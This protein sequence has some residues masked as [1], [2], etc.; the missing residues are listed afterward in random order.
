[1]K[2][3][4]VIE[5]LAETR[6]FFVES[7]KV[8]GFD[9]I[10][11]ENDRIAIERVQEELPDL[12]ISETITPKLDGYS[13]LST[14]RQNPITAIIPFIFVTARKTWTDIRFGMELGA[15]DYLTKPCTIEELLRAIATRI[16]KQ[17]TLKQWY[18]LE[19]QKTPEKS[20]HNTTA[21]AEVNQSIHPTGSPMREVFKFIEANYQQPITL[22]EVA[23]A[24]GY[25]P[26]YL[27]DLMRRQSGKTVHQWIVERRMTAAC[28]LLLETNRSV[29]EIAT[30][31][32]YSY[33]GCFFRQFRISFGMAPKAW[34]KTQVERQS[35]NS[36]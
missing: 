4:M 34:R 21:Q 19:H 30:A 15:D 16:E 36:G 1:M 6:N 13:V 25:A 7:L 20:T 8:S 2:K 10:G 32:G 26:A 3:I 14:L 17:S 22:T 5:E 28:S 11:A 23:Q 31:V 18:A 35:S 24:V 27:T 9:T 29:E 33:T 12:I